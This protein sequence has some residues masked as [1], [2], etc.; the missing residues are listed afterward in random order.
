V[1]VWPCLSIFC[2]FFPT[3]QEDILA[4]ARAHGGRVLVT[5]ETEAQ[6]GANGGS[7]R[8]VVEI[9]E[10]VTGPEAVQT[11]KQVRLP[12]LLGSLLGLLTSAVH[13]CCGLL[14]R[15]VALLVASALPAATAPTH[16]PMLPTPSLPAS[17]SRQVYDAL[18]AEG[19]RVTYVRIPL[20]DGA[21][22]LARD[23]DTFYSAAAA[24]GPSDALIYT[25]QV[26]LG[27]R[28]RG[29]GRG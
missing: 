17:L 26:G 3:E 6:A 22:P 21:C 16:T 28:G 2:F 4:E 20:T 23:F 10:P 15:V 1:C 19:Y 27:G 5:R 14:A 25:C 29:W 12:P 24:A 11:P 13:C 9:F 7:A 8:Q 18:V